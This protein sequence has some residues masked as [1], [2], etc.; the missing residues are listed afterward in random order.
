MDLLS[1]LLAEGR[2]SRLVRD[3]REEQQLVQG[4][5]SNF[6]LQKDA[7]LFTITAWLEPE[8]LERVESLIRLHLEDLLT[9]GI[10]PQ[11]L[12]RCQRLLCNDFAFSTE[13]PNQLA[14]L[15]GYYNTIAKVELAMIYPEKIQSYDAQQLQKLAQEYL[16]PHH[17]AVTVLKP[18]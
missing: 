13:T 12:T 16:S 11:E 17:Y 1:V 5:C 18:C 14:G 7:S 10:S 2:T 9:N 8:N 3:L 15:Y 6:S 4:I